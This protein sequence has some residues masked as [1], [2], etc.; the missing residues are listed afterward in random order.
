MDLINL[1]SFVETSLYRD[2]PAYLRYHSLRHV[3][4]VFE[5]VARIADSE[6]VSPEEK[7]LLQSAALL[8]D[9]GFIECRE[10]HEDVSCKYARIYLP[11]FG[12]PKSDIDA[13]CELIS[14][15]K[16]GH[17]PSN[18]LEKII[19]DADLEYLGREDYIEI[20]DLLFEELSGLGIISNRVQW[21]QLQLNFLL[22]HNFQTRYAQ[23]MG[24]Y[25]KR[26][27]TEI[28]ILRFNSLFNL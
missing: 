15:T 22:K 10:G 4:D 25:N 26:K 12:Y 28:L 24:A 11:L 16:I 1:K 27:Q 17:T 3:L 13:F 5:S 21:A 20:S 14:A 23:K 7:K 9:Y 19:M 6:N 2:F 18:I 8:H